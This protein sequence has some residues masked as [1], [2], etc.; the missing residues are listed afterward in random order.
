[1]EPSNLDKGFSGNL[2]DIGSGSLPD[3]RFGSIDWVDGCSCS[4]RSSIRASQCCYTLALKI[5]DA[6]LLPGLTLPIRLGP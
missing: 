4:R 5:L 2:I 6:Q 3:S 1:M